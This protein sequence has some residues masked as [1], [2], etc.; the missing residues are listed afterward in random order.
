MRH[1]LTRAM[2][3]AA[4]HA[5]LAVCY[6][7]LVHGA[8]PT[9]ARVAE[10][11]KDADGPAHCGRLVEAEQL[12][13]L[14][15]LAVRDGDSL[16]IS[17]FPSGTREL[18]DTV[19]VRGERTFAVWDYWSPVNTVVL[20][21]TDLDRVGYALLQRATDRLTEMP[22]EPLPSPD[23]QRVAVADFCAAGCD[24]EVAI[25]RIARDGIRRE[26]A[27]KPSETWS[28]VTLS[29]R[30]GET[31]ELEFTRVGQT[32]SQKVVRRLADP[33]WQKSEAR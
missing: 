9:P 30:D 2:A 8:A 24:N 1:S 26:S 20:F 16:R 32:Q 6:A 21:T 11:C 10:L 33:S 12:K 22:S 17:L 3:F 4:M 14:P 25:W 29:W 23:R 18:K 28:D 13:A 7:P 15:N 31:L 27:W 5:A 19:T